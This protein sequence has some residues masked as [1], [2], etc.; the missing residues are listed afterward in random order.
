LTSREAAPAQRVQRQNRQHL[1]SIEHDSLLVADHA[2]VAIAVVRNPQARPR[3]R[4]SATIASGCSLP[5]S[6]LILYPSG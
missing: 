6:R 5:I 3:V 1:V 4:T 2:P